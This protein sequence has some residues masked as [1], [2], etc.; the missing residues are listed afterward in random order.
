M[1]KFWQH[2]ARAN[3]EIR[4]E[5]V[6]KGWFERKTGSTAFQDHVRE[7]EASS[8]GRGADAEGRHPA[9]ESLYGRDASPAPDDPSFQAVYGRNPPEQGRAGD[10]YGRDAG[11]ER[12]D[13]PARQTG[14]GYDALEEPEPER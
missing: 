11:N 12:T 5:L 2:Y 6:D 1:S 13:S 4:T 8:A 14:Y 9:A 3:D 10:L 7:Q